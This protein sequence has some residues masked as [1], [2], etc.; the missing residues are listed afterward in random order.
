MVRHPTPLIGNRCQYQFGFVENLFVHG[1][2]LILVDPEQ[3]LFAS[4][5]ILGG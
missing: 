4:F 1:A 3:D 5:S 2:P